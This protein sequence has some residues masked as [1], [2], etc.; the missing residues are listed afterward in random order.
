MSGSRPS[1]GIR[2]SAEGAEQARRQIEAIGPAGESA[3]RRVAVASAAAA[4]EMQRLALASDVA[5]RA[6]TGMGGNLGRIGATFTGVSGVAAGLTAGFAALG[7][8]ATLGAVGIAKAGDAANQAMARLTT[9]AGGL[10]AAQTVYEGLF[11][12]SQ[13]TGVAITESADSFSRF[14]VAAKEIGGTNDQVLRLVSGIQKAGIVSGAS[15][16]EAGAAVQ[17]LGQALAAGTLQGDELRSVLENMPQ[18]A[19]ALAREMGVSLG[20]LKQ[21]GTE[22]KLTADK[23]F[24]AMLKAAESMS[25]EFDKMPKTMGMASNILGEATTNFLGKLDKIVN[26]SGLFRDAMLAGAGAINS[27]SSAIAPDDRQRAESGASGARGKIADLERQIAEIRERSPQNMGFRL[28]EGSALERT[29]ADQLAKLQASLATEQSA[30]AQHEAMLRL[31]ENDGR[32]QRGEE[33]TAAEV[34]RQ[35]A[36]RERGAR[37]VRDV[38]EFAD[39]KLKIARETAE[40]LKKIDEA[41]AAGVVTMPG[42]ARFDA[43]AARAGVLREQREELDK[44]AKEDGK[45]GTEAAKH[46]EKRQDVIDKLA[47]Q[48]KASEEALRATQGGTVASRESAIA[49]EIEAK[50]REAGIP[51]VEKRTEAEKRA[52]EAIGVSVRRLDQLATAND[53]AKE[54]QKKADDARKEA[55]AKVQSTTDD[56]VRYAGDRFADLFSNTSRGWAGVMDNF[57]TLAKQTF[58]RIAAEAVI[59]PIVTPIVQGVFGSSGLGGASGIGNLLGLSSLFPSGGLFGSLGLSSGI[60]GLLGASAISGWGSSTSAALGAMGGVFG[61]A[62]E[63]SVL[64]AGGGGLFGGAGAS[65]G[66]LLG[67]AGAG[68]GAG[69]FLNNLLGGNQTGGMVG[70]G[71]GALGGAVLGSIIP[72]IGTLIGGLIGGAAGGGLG[73]LIGPKESV[74]GWSYD[75]RSTASTDQTGFEAGDGLR[76]GNVFFNESGRQQF[77]QANATIAAINQYMASAGLTVSG[78]RAVGGN[79]NGPDDSWGGA[80]SFGEALGALRFQSKTDTRLTA[81]LGSQ[82]FDDPAKLQQ[83]VE[84]FKAAAAAIDA[85]GKESVPAFTA[86]LKAI[87]DNFDS[88]VEQARK[89]GLAEDN[90]TTARAKALAAMESQRAETLRQSDVSLSIRRLA[91]TGATMEAELAR[92]TEAARLELEAFGNSLD[93]LALGAADRAARLVQLEEVQAAERAAIIQRWGEQAAQ[94]LR[95]AGGNIRAYLDSLATGTAAGASPTDRL[96]AAQAAFEKDR[97]LSMGG[98]RDALGR[99][100]GSADALLSA[101][102]DMFAS[103]PEFQAIL[104]SV[105]TGLGGLPVLQSYDAMQAA[106][107]EAIQEAIE[108]GTLNTSTTILPSGNIVS[109]ANLGELAS[110][111]PAIAAMHATL[112]QIHASLYDIGGVTNTLIANLHA[113]TLAIGA[114]AAQQRHDQLATAVQANAT[115]IQQIAALVS[116]GTYLAAA[117]VFASDLNWRINHLEQ[118]GEAINGGVHFGNTVTANGTVATSAGLAALAKI[119]ADAS[120]ASVAGFA[121]L[122]KVAADGATAGV[123][124]QTAGNTIAGTAAAAIVAAIGA[125]NTIAAQAAQASTA[126]LAAMNKI[127]VDG[128]AAVVTSLA[129]SNTLL[130]GILAKP[131]GVANDNLAGPLGNLVQLGQAINGNVAPLA[132]LAAVGNNHAATHT[133]H[134]L[135][136][137]ALGQGINGA[138]APLAGALAVANNWLATLR[139]HAIEARDAQNAG[140]TIAAAAANAHTLSLGSLNTNTVALGN[141]HTQGLAAITAAIGV[142]SSNAVAIGASHTGGL[143]NINTSLGTVDKSV[144]DVNA[145][146]ATVHGA[147]VSGAAGQVAAQSAGNVIAFDAAKASTAGTAALNTLLAASGAATVQA[148]ATGHGIANQVGAS[149][150]AALN[151][152][153]QIAASNTTLLFQ[154]IGAGNTIEASNAVF[155]NTQRAELLAAVG[156]LVARVEALIATTQQGAT[157]GAAETRAAGIRVENAVLEV[158]SAV[159]DAA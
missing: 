134:L 77:D 6:F 32:R 9:A 126:S 41:E 5:N 7:A 74:R 39:K 133:N 76:M 20:A 8:A 3:M 128:N 152:A 104:A 59:R 132:G 110:I 1:V 144:R 55:E 21:M 45:A 34:Q 67:G 96:A 68:F 47:L 10:Q 72:G 12:L 13:Q 142:Q 40:K 123:A 81:Y 84:G 44:L 51:G 99:V 42:G 139:N 93:A 97:L 71:V 119:G 100:T 78:A 37:D 27:I 22:G 23:V 131:A 149:T 112:G 140:N 60:S 156:G 86:S 56:V 122:T 158:K 117:N 109:I 157:L 95:Q 19:Q 64:A 63:A 57:Y 2:V 154:A 102:R 91:A 49:L 90:L 148:L 125:A 73:G 94:A 14:A 106:S 89:Y 18:F 48:V 70:S 58:A 35:V 151:A 141:A 43:A 155:A 54:A 46:A 53:R 88:G 150:I 129:L 130:A 62:T 118:L 79:K 92:Q 121:A 116:I 113:S 26:A 137:I 107:L 136:L 38:A 124:A 145:S 87:N 159:K 103:A 17:Q 28:P 147:I 85:L 143:V 111:G 66:S 83:A 65:F 16:Q 120:A 135:N 31:I 61:P 24:P 29:R 69:M 98:D 127:L 33:A 114:Q 80:A 36:A 30:L 108:N 138:A 50:V 75:L 101:G 146:L 115:A 105:K 4:P 15:A 25:A 82:S 11:Q 52:A 153:N